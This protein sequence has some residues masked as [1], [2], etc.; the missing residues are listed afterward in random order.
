[1]TT[2]IM[3]VDLLIEEGFYYELINITVNGYWP[4]TFA[5]VTWPLTDAFYIP[6]TPIPEIID[7]NRGVCNNMT[8]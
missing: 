7:M 3:I 5:F 6:C 4:L 2:Y 8:D 1:M